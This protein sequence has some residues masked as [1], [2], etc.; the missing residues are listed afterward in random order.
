MATSVLYAAL[1]A[2]LITAGWLLPVGLIRVLA[3]RSGGPDSTPGMRK[4]AIFALGL[5]C[6]AIVA[7]LIITSIIATR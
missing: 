5:G 1:L 3:Y 4:L 6:V 7:A 2:T